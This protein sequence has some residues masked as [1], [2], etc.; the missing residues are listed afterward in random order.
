MG[1]VEWT[2]TL[3]AVGSAV[4][5][6]GAWQVA[7]RA[8]QTAESARKTAET[9]ARI[10]QHRIHHEMTPS[11]EVSI[12]KQNPSVN[13]RAS[14]AVTWLGPSTLAQLTE[15]RVEI[16]N[17]GRAHLPAVAS[18]MRPTAQD[19]TQTVWGP[20]RLQPGISGALLDG[21]S[22]RAAVVELGTAVKL[23]LEQTPCPEWFGGPEW[24]HREY[25]GTPVRLWVEAR[26]PDFRP[27]RQAY[28]VPVLEPQA[29]G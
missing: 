2:S 17:D 28:E 18:G 7:W 5:A 14:L 6:G 26:H 8:G 16:R 11:F 23:D 3:A 15:I 9:V 19:I 29:T 13:S 10:E 1:A 27:W 4:A 24:W 12:T 20:Y 25:A 22:A 21:R